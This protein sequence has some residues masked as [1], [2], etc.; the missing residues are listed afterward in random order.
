MSAAEVMILLIVGIVVVGPQR[1]PTMMRW[2]GRNIAKLRRLSSDL[3]AQSG[4]DRIIREEG[5]EKEIAELRALRDSLSRQA[6]LDGLVNAVNAPPPPPKPRPAPKP[7]AVTAASPAPVLPP[8]P[9]T[10]A[11]TAPAAE[12]APAPTAVATGS[13][14]TATTTT[15]GAL[16]KPAPNA[17]PR[18]GAVVRPL[19]LPTTPV[20]SEPFKSFRAREYPSYGPD[21]YGALPD[22][23]DD[24]DESDLED[25][26]AAAL[27]GEAPSAAD[28]AEETRA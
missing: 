23:I 7:P 24:S 8:A 27:V 13:D 2:A 5:L 21:H 15:A 12:P 19:G 6:M 22:D 26:A 11:S 3:R 14:G 17:I 1:L 20:S 4:I 25:P 16:I 28:P 9:E 10:P 18:S